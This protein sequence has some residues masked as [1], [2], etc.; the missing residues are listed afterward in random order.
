[1]ITDLDALRTRL[2][3]VG[4]KDDALLASCLDAATAW[5]EDRVYDI[6]D[7]RLGQRH[8]EVTE[9]ILLMASRLFKRRQSPEGVAGWSDLGAVRIVSRDPDVEALLERHIDYGRAGIA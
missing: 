2:G 5:V 1:V 9:A 6:P 4:T 8:P 7:A 3:T